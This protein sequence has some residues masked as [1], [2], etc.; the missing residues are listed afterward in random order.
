MSHGTE[1]FGGGEGEG[2]D[3]AGPGPA[4]PRRAGGTAPAD[5]PDFLDL[6]VSVTRQVQ[7]SGPS[8]WKYLATGVDSLDLGLYVDWKAWAQ[9]EAALDKEKKA[10]ERTKG[11]PW[12]PGQ[13]VNCLILPGGKQP[14]Y[15]FHLQSADF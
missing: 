10:A 7:I 6:A 1:S 13:V 4:R 14:M 5:P 9:L 12:R 15:A 8:E 3:G 2:D 11:I